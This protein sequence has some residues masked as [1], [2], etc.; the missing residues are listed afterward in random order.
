MVARLCDPKTIW[1]PFLWGYL[2]SSSSFTRVGHRCGRFTASHSSRFVPH[3][4]PW[5]GGVLIGL[6]ELRRQCLL[7]IRVTLWSR[8]RMADGSGLSFWKYVI[9]LPP[10]GAQVRVGA[11]RLQNGKYPVILDETF[12][13]S[14]ES[15]LCWFWLQ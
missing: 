3:L 15:K 11:R 13:G 8:K 7:S 14:E 6:G 1:G 9:I 12:H 4:R 10:Q 2:L 5:I